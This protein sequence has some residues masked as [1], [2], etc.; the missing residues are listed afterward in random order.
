M[1][2]SN[3]PAQLAPG[4]S[5]AAMVLD[6]SALISQMSITDPFW[7][8]PSNI[9]HVIFAYTDATGSEHQQL[10]FR[11]DNQAALSVSSHVRKNTWIVKQIILMDADGGM[12]TIA[13]A[14]FANPT[15]FDILVDVVVSAIFQQLNAT[16]LVLATDIDHT[17][18]GMKF[19]LAASATINSV[20]LK[21]GQT[22]AASDTGNVF[23]SIEQAAPTAPYQPHGDAFALGR[24]AMVASAALPSGSPDFMTFPLSAPLTL[25]A[26]TYWV[27][28]RGDS[29]VA[30]FDNGTCTVTL[31]GN[32][33]NS[34]ANLEVTRLRMS[35]STYEFDATKALYCEI[36]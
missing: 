35:T 29:D 8:D 18:M 5:T 21:L 6:R 3:K 13:R 33:S 28:F 10:V 36:T 22:G 20:K 4:S 23:V 1:I 16:D 32:A 27:M 2:L 12:H 25:S 15:E 9:D 14:Q 30:P 7:S 17:D 24:S 11:G 26:G 19:T 34:D 31:A